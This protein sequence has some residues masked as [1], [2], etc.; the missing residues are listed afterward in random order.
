MDVHSPK[1][2]SYNMSKIK[3]KD[4]KPE[5]LVR[6]WLWRKGF[7]YRLHRKDLPGK[8]DIVLTKYNAVLFIHGCFW[9]RHGC[10]LSATPE[11]RKD[12]WLSKLNG[13]VERE[14]LNFEKLLEKGWRIGVIW[15]CIFKSKKQFPEEFG[16]QIVDWLYSDLPQISL[17]NINNNGVK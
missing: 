1:Q 9:H 12:F 15:E 2:R 7:R 6:K 11:T 4:T 16:N 13:N 8:P 17:E 3:G 14:K 10:H 5:I